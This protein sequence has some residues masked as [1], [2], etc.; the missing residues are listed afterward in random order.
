MFYPYSQGY[1]APYDQNAQEPYP[2]EFQENEEP[3]P[4]VQQP[5]KSKVSIQAPF[6][7]YVV[8]A[9]DQYPYEVVQCTD[10]PEWTNAL[11]CS[12]Y[13][14]LAKQLFM[15]TDLVADLTPMKMPKRL[16]I[17]PPSNAVMSSLVS[18]AYPCILDPFGKFAILLL[19]EDI[20]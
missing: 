17:F 12:V 11:R 4:P 1:Q 20:W 18:D 10:V 9:A 19:L 16:R 13:F 3:Q 7:P 5:P 6:G 2:E 14:P 15:V 8:D